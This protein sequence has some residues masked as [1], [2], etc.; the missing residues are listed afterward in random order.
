M[1]ALYAKGK[2]SL[3]QDFHHEGL[4]GTIF[5]ERLIQE[6]QVGNFRAVIPIIRG[7]PW[8]TGFARYVVDP[9][10]LF[11]NGFTLGDIRGDAM[12]QPLAH[13]PWRINWHNWIGV[14]VECQIECA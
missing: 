9:D 5:V 2:L 3:N 10:D 1:A 6:T 7:Q 12:E 14:S 4:L 13:Y 11:P 8:I